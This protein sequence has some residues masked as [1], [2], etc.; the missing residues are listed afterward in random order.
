MSW[1]L[2][3]FILTCL[4]SLYSL[5]LRFNGNFYAADLVK[6]R[7]VLAEVH[8]QQQLGCPSPTPRTTRTP[9]C[10][11]PTRPPS[12]R[13]S[14]TSSAARSTTANSL[15]ASQ[16]RFLFMGEILSF[17]QI[18]YRV[19]RKII[20]PYKCIFRASNSKDEFTDTFTKRFHEKKKIITAIQ[21]K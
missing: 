13:F 11:P 12:S 5:S 7:L 6:L 15:V 10:W 20:F 18:L 1:K 2:L 21:I 19:L 4:K 14:P 9:R 17:F 16:A 8:L 3:L